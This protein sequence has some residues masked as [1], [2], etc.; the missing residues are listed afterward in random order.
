MVKPQPLGLLLDN[1]LDIEH[2][3][4]FRVLPIGKA[5]ASDVGS[6]TDGEVSVGIVAVRDLLVRQR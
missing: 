5:Q 1:H 6:G 4:E 2:H 3:R